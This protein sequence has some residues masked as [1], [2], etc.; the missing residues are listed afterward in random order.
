MNVRGFNHIAI[1][2]LDLPASIR[3]YGDLLGFTLQDTADAGEFS[4]TNLVFPGGFVELVCMHEAPG[5]G[6]DRPSETVHHLAFDVE[7]V[8]A[9]ERSLRQAGVEIVQPST[10][11]VEFKSKVVKFRDPNGL[12]LAFRQDL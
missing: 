10:T 3:F 9:A 11:L 7:D 8:D 5:P 2:T 4:S 6:S 1:Q 12:V